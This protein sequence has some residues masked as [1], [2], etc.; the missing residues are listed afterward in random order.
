[1]FRALTRLL[2]PGD[3]L[4]SAIDKRDADRILYIVGKRQFGVLGR[5]TSDGVDPFESTD[6]EVIEQIRTDVVSMSGDQ[7]IEP[8]TVDHNGRMAVI[9]FTKPQFQMAY[10]EQ[11]VLQLNRIVG[12]PAYEISGETLLGLLQADVDVLLDPGSK[13]QRVLQLRYFAEH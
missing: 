10:V 7:P 6:E 4:L 8:M 2:L 11:L 1:M 9:A 12:V 3:P 5:L 13:N